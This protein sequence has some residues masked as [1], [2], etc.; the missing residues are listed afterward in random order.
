MTR[1]WKLC[2][3]FILI[4]ALAFCA[5]PPRSDPAQAGMDPARLAM[6]AE[7]MQEEVAHNHTA[8]TVTLL[9]RH[10]VIAHFEAT[11]WADIEAKKPM[12][13]D[14][15]FQIMSMSKPMAG[16]AIMMLVDEGRVRLI[17]PVETYLPEF[18]GQ[19]LAV[20]ENG[21]TTL[22]KPARPITVRDLMMHCSGLPGEIS[23]P[24][25][26]LV[27]KMHLTIEQAVKLTAQQPLQF[28]PGTRWQYSN[29]GIATLGRIV[30]VVS[31]M[32]YEEFLA[33]RLFA[34]LGMVD[35]FIFLPADRHARLAAVYCLKDGH[36][37]KAGADILG[38]DPYQFRAG[39]V[40]AA[41]DF[42]VYSTAT[43]LSHFYQ[44]MLNK[45]TY[46][47]KR[48]LS[49]AA[50]ETMTMVQ[51]GD[52]KAGWVPGTGFGLTWEVTKDPLGT[53]FGLGLGAFHH[54]G[55]FGTFGYIDPKRDL[56]GVYLTQWTGSDS[57]ATR[58]RFLQIAA[59]SIVK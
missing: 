56:V 10:G 24:G 27:V 22:R 25:G 1:F 30:E 42:G 44:M 23:D 50:I 4:A 53:V 34:P 3:S 43:D 15:I 17:D 39:A 41:P 47:G 35:S 45:G 37:V 29:P 11:G 6:V 12:Q 18:H 52:I 51:T 55:A 32:K 31:G 33:K 5:A 28:E 59:A 9:I 26:R 13:R 19:M 14:T 2:C 57:T 36:M 38:G 54:G 8:G 58:D 7:R 46:N 20:Q 21:Q 16:A 40:Y 48:I 49:P